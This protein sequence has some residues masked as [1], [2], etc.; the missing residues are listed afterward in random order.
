ME[1]EEGGVHIAAATVQMTEGRERRGP[2]LLQKRGSTLTLSLLC[3][4]DLLLAAASGA[5]E[6]EE[7]EGDNRVRE[8]HPPPLLSR[9]HHL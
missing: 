5:G 6:K 7:G 2:P 4:Q 8:M 9:C 1:E 3:K